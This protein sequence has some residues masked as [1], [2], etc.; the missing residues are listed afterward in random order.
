MSKR[1]GVIFTLVAM[2]IVA[3]A[4]S[5]PFPAENLQLWLRADSVELTDGKVSRWYDLSPNQ[6]EIVQTN[7]AARPT[8]LADAL[9]GQP[10]LTFN[11]AQQL[12]GQPF[13]LLNE[14]WTFFVVAKT[15]AKTSKEQLLIGNG[16]TGGGSNRY[17]LNIDCFS[18]T[19]HTPYLTSWASQINDNS[20]YIIDFECRNDK[21][22][23]LFH[24]DNN[25][26]ATISYD[27]AFGYNSGSL[28]IG[29]YD[30]PLHQSLNGQIAEVIVFNTA[31]SSLRSQVAE[32]LANKYFPER[33][34]SVSLGLDIH[35][36]Y[37][38]ADTAI[39]TAYNPNFVSYL[40]STG[41]TDSVIHVSN[42]VSYWVT[43]T[44][45]FGYTSTDTINVFS[46]SG[47]LHST[48]HTHTCGATAQRVARSK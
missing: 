35:V 24:V 30:N 38:F 16:A 11:G 1:I 12:V 19:N 48:D 46:L 7:A 21:R 27:A 20:F 39:T 14:N 31:D 32:Y 3:I 42:P 29:A 47:I 43:V 36:P 5:L 18:S 17:R 23:G 41:E 34:A 9:N 4:Q 33:N 10:V 6:Y 44:N 8:F 13:S 40:W 15:I 25:L 28:K 2:H 26:V 37:G 22:R 45:A